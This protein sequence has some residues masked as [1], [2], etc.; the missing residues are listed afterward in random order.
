MPARPTLKGYQPEFNVRFL[1]NLFNPKKK[2]DNR[3]TAEAKFE[4]L[5]FLLEYSVQTGQS[6]HLASEGETDRSQVHG[7]ADTIVELLWAA[8]Q[9]DIDGLRR[10]VVQGVPVSAADYDGRTALHLAAA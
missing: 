9:N 8:A 5:T 3:A 6:Q 10:L 4:V 1:G 7:D 2:T